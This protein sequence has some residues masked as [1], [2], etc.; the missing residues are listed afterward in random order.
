MKRV[1]FQFL[2]FTF[3][4]DGL[5]P[6]EERGEERGDREKERERERGRK[7]G[8]GGKNLWGVE[9]KDCEIC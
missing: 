4:E 2:V 7:G 1:S 8:G 6:R 3:S 9:W 5:S